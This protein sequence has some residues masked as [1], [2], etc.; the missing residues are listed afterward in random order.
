M[1]EWELQKHVQALI[2]YGVM[3]LSW[4]IPIP[5]GKLF[6]AFIP[7]FGECS[8]QYANG[9]DWEDRRKCLYRVFKGESLL[10]YFRHFIQIAK[11]NCSLP[12]S[13]LSYL[14]YFLLYSIINFIFLF[15]LSSLSVLPSIFLSPV[16]PSSLSSSLH[17]RSS[18]PLPSLSPSSSYLPFSLL[19]PSLCSLPFCERPSQEV[20][21]AWSD[22]GTKEH[23]PLIKSSFSMTIKGIV[24]CIFGKDLTDQDRVNKLTESYITVWHEL[25]V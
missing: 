6:A 3:S 14:S 16:P 24:R 20:E 21:E 23:I 25:E 15:I 7:L 17:P 4:S 22:S 13:F 8:I 10:S 1:G 12:L 9:T 19:F 18:D 11:V 5:L 2:N